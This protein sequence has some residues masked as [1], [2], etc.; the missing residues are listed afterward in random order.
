MVI[1]HNLLA[2]NADR[3]YGITSNRKAKTT[4]KLSSGYRVNRAADDAAGLAIS[5]KM[6]RQIRG[7]TR[8][9]ENCQDGV[10]LVQI[11]DGAMSEVHDMLDRCTELS[12]KA[13]NGTLNDVDRDYIQ[14]EISQIKEEIDKI[15]ERTTFNEIPVLKGTDAI[16]VA[17]TGGASIVGGL[18]AWVNGGASLGAGKIVESVSV[19][20]AS[21]LGG[22]LDFTN[23]DA[24]PSQVGTKLA[25]LADGNSGF[26]MTCC[27][28][29]EHYSVK[30]VQ[31]AAKGVQNSGGHKIYEVS[32][33]GIT[34]S[35]ALV[36][37]IYSTIGSPVG[38]HLLK[39]QANGGKLTIYDSR[40]A[41]RSSVGK[42][43]G[44]LMPG[45]AY[46]DDEVPADKPF[47]IRIQ[48]GAESG[49]YIDI[50]LPAIGCS[51]LKIGSANV[52]TEESAQNAITL[53]KNA[54][55]YVSEQ[56]SRMG[57]YQNRME[58]TIKNLDNVVEN[59]TAAES[60]IRDADMAKESMSNSVSNILMQAGESMLSQANQSKQ[61]ILTLMQ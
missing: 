14:K 1:Q 58:H 45:V 25:E 48:A 34:S 9:S 59:T 3:M 19:G 22:V 50:K 57:A 61:G 12:I 7:L 21:Y 5:E 36:S 35:S 15:K 49:Q 42:D 6:R 51:A 37:R 16:G 31:G 18:P 38:G 2:M 41:D 28:C 52:T 56:R 39:A 32:V 53:F 55:E 4:E 20:G 27:T 40:Y 33:D 11:A 43:R 44:L 17:S 29:D 54:K 60:R 30:F 26:N 10:S 23:L 46:D 47:D 8:A 13:A 24:D